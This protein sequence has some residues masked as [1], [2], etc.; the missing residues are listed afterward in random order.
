MS[1]IEVSQKPVVVQRSRGNFTKRKKSYAKLLLGLSFELACP[2]SSALLQWPVSNLHIPQPPLFGC[3]QGIGF[4]AEP[5]TPDGFSQIFTIAELGLIG[6][7][8]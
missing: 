1:K 3:Q 6:G 8:N 4:Q 5:G 2:A 7:Q